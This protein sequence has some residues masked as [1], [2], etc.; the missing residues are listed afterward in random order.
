[1]SLPNLNYEDFTFTLD[2]EAIK[3]EIDKVVIEAKP[4]SKLIKGEVILDIIKI[5]KNQ[6]D[7]LGT[8]KETIE[9][10]SFLSDK[11]DK[12]ITNIDKWETSNNNDSGAFTNEAKAIK[13]ISENV[14]EKIKTT[15]NIT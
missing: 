9:K 8:V 10:L 11:I 4:D 2:K 15:T 13:E 7:E 14:K 3:D 5:T 1:M 12:N 6:R